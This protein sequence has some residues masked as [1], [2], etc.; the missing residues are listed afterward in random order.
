MLYY[1]GRG[2]HVS[3]NNYTFVLEV[4][5]LRA[6]RCVV[7]SASAERNRARSNAAGKSYFL[8]VSHSSSQAQGDLFEIRDQVRGSTAHL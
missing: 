5:L 1:Q 4:Q 6:A 2:R 3:A 7:V 8:L